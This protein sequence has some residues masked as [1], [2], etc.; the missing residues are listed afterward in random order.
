M[1]SNKSD[2]CPNCGTQLPNEENFCPNC[3]Q[4]NT[5]LNLSIW[6]VLKDF[7]G[8]YF[9][10]D[11]KLFITLGPLIY[12]PG[13]VPKEYI[14]G[15]RVRHIPPL[16]IFIF[17]SFITF[18]LWGLSFQGDKKDD[19]GDAEKNTIELLDSARTNQTYIDSLNEASDLI[20]W[21]SFK[22]SLS[23]DSNAGNLNNTSFD[24]ILNKENDP[25]AIA[26]SIVG[27]SNRVIKHF[28]YQSLRMYQAEDGAVTKYFLGNI[29]L[30]LLLLQPFFALLLKVF[31][32]R[33]K[34][35]F[36]IEHLVF[37]LYFHA[38][39]LLTTILLY[40][41]SHFIDSNYLILW[42]IIIAMLY[43]ILAIKRF[44][45]QSW[46]KSFVKSGGISFLYLTIVF[47]AFMIAYLLLSLY[48]Y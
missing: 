12:K 33:R 9:T 40:F 19:Q 28:M 14:E 29:S 47:P 30:V 13:A 6:E 22:D 48:F 4:K 44:Y 43:L 25:R 42:L 2:Q 7:S 24:Y 36:Y 18:F 15:K 27:D 34:S 26:D 5:D 39:I 35:F 3:G 41:L 17:L 1:I 11:S 20:Q 46:I 21:S 8:D 31:Y 37:S 32:I 45:M 38:F 23:S 16:R 10:F